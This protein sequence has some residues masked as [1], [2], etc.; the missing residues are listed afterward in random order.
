[1]QTKHVKFIEEGLLHA[2][3]LGSF[4]FTVDYFLLKIDKF[5]AK[6]STVVLIPSDDEYER[7]L[8]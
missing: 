2:K 3:K 7:Y 6:E 8:V 1:M 5:F 4:G